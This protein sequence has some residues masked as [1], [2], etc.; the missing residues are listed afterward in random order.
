MV[1]MPLLNDNLFCK[2]T[3]WCVIAK[4]YYNEISSRKP[5]KTREIA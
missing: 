5:H 1:G 4:M 3:I 2:E